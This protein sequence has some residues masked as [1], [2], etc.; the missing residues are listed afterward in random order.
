MRNVYPQE[1]VS[2]IHFVHDNC[3]TH[4]ARVTKTW[5]RQHPDVTEITWPSKSPDLNPIENIWGIMVQMWV[6]G[7]ER[8]K[9]ALEEH[10]HEVWESLR[11]SDVCSRIVDSMPD[12]LR[13]VSDSMG[14]YTRY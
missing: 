6:N 5:F 4:K 1:D 2:N 11:G 13:A 7:Q 8:T 3:P 10:C 9:Q 12:R 14:A